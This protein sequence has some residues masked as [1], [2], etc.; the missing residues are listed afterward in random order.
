[1]LDDSFF[2]PDS[3]TVRFWVQIDDAWVGASIGKESLHYHFR[4]DARDDDPLETYRQHAT[5]LEA[6][7]R[8]RVSRGAREPVMLRD[9]D[10]AIP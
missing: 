1:M 6:A 2:H 4:P 3:G 10:L 7:V 5:Q 8:L 9:A